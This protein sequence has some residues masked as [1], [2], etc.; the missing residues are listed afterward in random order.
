MAGG[1]VSCNDT[2]VNICTDVLKPAV[3]H[4]L[5]YST[6]TY[7]GEWILVALTLSDLCTFLILGHSK[8]NKNFM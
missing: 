6:R 4:R 1:F 7:L 8:S 2:S 3:K 5:P